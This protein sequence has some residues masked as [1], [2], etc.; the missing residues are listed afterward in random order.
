MA[1]TASPGTARVS[2]GMSAPPMQA[3]FEDSLAIIPS[4]APSPNGTSGFFTIRFASLYAINDA[5]G[6]PA[7]G[8]APTSMPI[9]EVYRESFQ[10]FST[11]FKLTFVFSMDR[12]FCSCPRLYTT[13]K[14][15]AK[16][17]K[18]TSAGTVLIP[19]ARFWIPKVS[20]LVPISGSRPIMLMIRP[21]I[22]LTRPF[23]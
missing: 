1:V 15:S 20:R 23:A 18:P 14:T 7:P 13:L 17:K 8:R 22:T 19:P 10:C 5:T 2:I 16:P 9:V 11:S 3:L 6:P 4:T 21:S 12:T